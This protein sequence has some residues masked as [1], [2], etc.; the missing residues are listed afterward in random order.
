MNTVI[1]FLCGIFTIILT[2]L[3]ALLIVHQIDD[4]KLLDELLLREKRLGYRLNA[5]ERK[6]QTDEMSGPI[7]GNLDRNA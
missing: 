5:L 6:Q 2:T 3:V 7:T 1:A 4:E